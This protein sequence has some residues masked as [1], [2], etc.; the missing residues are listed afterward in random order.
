MSMS[1]KPDTLR[2]EETVVE[3]ESNS[4]PWTDVFQEEG[5]TTPSHAT[6]TDAPSQ[7]ERASQSDMDA[8]SRATHEALLA[9][10]A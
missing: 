4:S 2:D 3:M 6:H 1:D 10:F 9:I 7:S 8:D 5:F